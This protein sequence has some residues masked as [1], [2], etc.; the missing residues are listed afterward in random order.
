MLHDNED[1]Q[2]V[3]MVIAGLSQAVYCCLFYVYEV[4]TILS[5]H[6]SI[7]QINASQFSPQFALLLYHQTTGKVFPSQ[8]LNVS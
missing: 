1:R 6:L 3:I 2:L 4:S 8:M 5:S 7:V